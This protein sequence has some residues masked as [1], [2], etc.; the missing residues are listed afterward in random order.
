[1][2][3]NQEKFD[4]A[5][6]IQQKLRRGIV[7]LLAV[8]LPVAALI[9]AIFERNPIYVCGSWWYGAILLLLWLM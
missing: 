5:P 4:N 8:L 7:L 6:S 1:M 3:S 2:A 9:A